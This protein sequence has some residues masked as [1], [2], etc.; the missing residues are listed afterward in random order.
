MNVVKTGSQYDIFHDDLETYMGLPAQVYKVVFSERTG[1]HLQKSFDI[2]VKEDKVY[3]VHITKVEK[4]LNSYA[5][6]PR[7]LGVILSGAKG[8]GKSLF[9]KMICSEGVKKGYPVVL[10]SEYHQGI[11][12]YLEK[13]QQEVIIVFDEFDKTFKKEAQD[14]MLTLFD[15]FAQTKQMYVVTCNNIDLLSD[16]LVNRPGRFHYHLRFDYPDSEQIV[17]Y[18]KDKLPETLWGE[19]EKVVL[20]SKKINLNYDCLRAIAFELS[21]GAPFEEAIKDI[22]IIN[23]G[24]GKYYTA[25]LSLSDGKV[26]KREVRIDLFDSGEQKIR[27][28][29]GEVDL[30][31][32]FSGTQARYDKEMDKL[33]VKPKDIKMELNVWWDSDE[34]E[35]EKKWNKWLAEV[36]PTSLVMSVEPAQK[37]I[38]YA[39]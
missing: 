28:D 26:F 37:A 30:D 10:V 9:A 4:I 12:D 35:E 34:K 14:E 19:I 33:T 39:V 13:I 20:F 22:N 21:L 7:N 11:A 18:L 32:K 15:G 31:V 16:Y 6:F 3:G 23:D 25:T 36:K 5:I 27:F 2:E 24:R 17:E 29:V 8:I 1:F 38:H